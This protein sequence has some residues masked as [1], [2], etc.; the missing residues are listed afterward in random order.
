MDTDDDISVSLLV[1][2]FIYSMI[3]AEE[4]RVKV[5]QD[6]T[7]KRRGRKRRNIWILMM[8]LMFHFLLFCLFTV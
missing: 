1:V 4:I 8:T 7:M 3:I 6:I 5:R 2:L